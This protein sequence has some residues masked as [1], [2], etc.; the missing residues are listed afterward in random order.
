MG[1]VASMPRVLVNKD[2]FG[3]DDG[4][5][6]DNRSPTFQKVHLL[7]IAAVYY[8]LIITHLA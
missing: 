2:Y 1:L 7:F 4:R 3:V 5:Y 6:S 8:N